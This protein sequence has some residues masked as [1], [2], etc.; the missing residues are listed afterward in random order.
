MKYIPSPTKDPVEKNKAVMNYVCF[1]TVLF[2]SPMYLSAALETN[3][4]TTSRWEKPSYIGQLGLAFHVAENVYE[5]I[6]YLYQG[7]PREF[8]L[9]H[10]VVIINFVPVR[11][12][13]T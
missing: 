8:Y 13:D 7:K 1:I 9:H 4:S 11:L 5:S 3:T 2:L 10:L 12:V 6:N